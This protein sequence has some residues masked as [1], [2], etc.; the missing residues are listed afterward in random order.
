MKKIILIAALV[1]IVITSGVLIGLYAIGDKIIDE[2]IETSIPTI[3]ATEE[4]ADEKPVDEKLADE[5]EINDPDVVELGGKPALS[6]KNSIAVNE[7]SKEKKQEVTVE[8][9]NE[10]KDKVTVQDKVA[11]AAMVMGKLSSSEINKLKGMLS[12]GLTKEEK[13]EAKKIAFS[14]F[15]N[16]EIKQIKEMYS[17][18]MTKD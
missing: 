11:A 6:S 14:N 8:K 1:L 17:K 13:E 9:M 16:E 4:L 10:V 2:L 5:K 12:G 3:S 18:Y 7:S 15:S